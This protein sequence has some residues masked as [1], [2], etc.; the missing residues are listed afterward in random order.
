MQSSDYQSS[1]LVAYTYFSAKTRRVIGNI[2]Y[3][4][5]VAFKQLFRILCHISRKQTEIMDH[6]TNQTQTI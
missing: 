3:H 5:N 1:A 4:V 6:F 2:I